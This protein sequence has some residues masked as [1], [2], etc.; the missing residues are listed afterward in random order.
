M[1]SV[2]YRT[3]I[4]IKMNYRQ[5][6][7]ICYTDNEWTFYPMSAIKRLRY[8]PVALY[9]YLIGRIGQ[10]VAPGEFDR[11]AEMFSKVYSRMVER[12]D[13]LP[14]DMPNSVREF[15]VNRVIGIY[16]CE[17]F[18][19]GIWK[20]HT[21]A[22]DSKLKTIDRWMSATNAY[23]YSQLVGAF[24]SRKLHVN[25]FELWRKNYSSR[26]FLFGALRIAR[27]ISG[28]LSRKKVSQRRP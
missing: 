26:T 6:E 3:D 23:L 5:T 7:G 20:T 22:S 11:N 14:K 28:I 9:Q 19:N 18:A 13:S 16:Y 27:R 12:W 15:L 25:L 1:H 21:I 8:E 17:L 10:S 4:V 2:T 24:E